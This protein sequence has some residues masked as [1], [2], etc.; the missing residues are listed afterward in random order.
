M[1]SSINSSCSQIDAVKASVPQL[2][3]QV[4][5]SSAAQDTQQYRK[6]T[7]DIQNVNSTIQTGDPKK[8][9]AALQTAQSD[10]DELQQ[11]AQKAKS[12]QQQATG[13]RKNFRS[14]EAVA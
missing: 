14:F 10:V 6:A 2:K 1:S 11:V 8:A 5:Q 13:A 12:A 9:K 4:Y 3:A 7:S